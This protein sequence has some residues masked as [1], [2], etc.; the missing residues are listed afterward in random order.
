MQIQ[1][2][3]LSFSSG[4]PSMRLH[5]KARHPQGWGLDPTEFIRS[6]SENC[7]S[8]ILSELEG[9]SHVTRANHAVYDVS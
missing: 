2:S 4:V 5:Q 1:R 9:M 6:L 3:K 8:L 7:C